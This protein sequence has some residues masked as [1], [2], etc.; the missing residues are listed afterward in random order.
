M[1]KAQYARIYVEAGASAQALNASAGTFN[2]LTCF[3]S[4]GI[5]YGD[6][7][8]SHANDNIVMATDGGG[9]DAMPAELAFS[10]SFTV[11]TAGLYRFAL[12]Q[13]NVLVPGSERRI[14]C[15]LATTYTV[16]GRTLAAVADGA[17]PT[18]D[19]RAASD[20]SAPN[21]TVSYASLEARITG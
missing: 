16:S 6:A 2:K 21:I 1:S 12:Y 14:T 15:A 10:V 8:P 20:Q 11:D 7:T 17:E 19:L 3:A 4:D 9:G 5:S 13:D 18:F